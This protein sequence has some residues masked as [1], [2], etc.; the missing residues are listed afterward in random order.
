MAS[1]KVCIV[2]SGNWS[3]GTICHGSGGDKEGAQPSPRLWVA[4]Q[5]S[6]HSLTHG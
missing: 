3:L 2:G 5:P 4:M 6:W 1:K